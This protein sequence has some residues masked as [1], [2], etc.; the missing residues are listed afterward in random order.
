MKNSIFDFI[1]SLAPRIERPVV[2][3][4]IDDT[5]KELSEYALPMTRD[6]A[7][8]AGLGRMKSVTYLKLTKEFEA[9]G[10]RL[11]GDGNVFD[12]MIQH[13]TTLLLNAE[14]ARKFIDAYL[15]HD[16]V[17]DGITARGAVLLRTVGSMSFASRFT[18]DLLN[19]ILDE[20][21]ALNNKTRVD[22]P[23]KQSI[24]V[25]SNISRYVTILLELGNDAKGFKKRFEDMPD[26][27][28]RE[29]NADSI[30]NLY[31]ASSINIFPRTFSLNGFRGNPIYHIRLMINEWEARRYNAAKDKKVILELRLMVLQNQQSD[32]YNPMAEK[33][34]EN[35]QARIEKYDRFIR[36]TEE[37]VKD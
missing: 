6:M 27:Y 8:Q 30:S 9:Q 15:G 2:L 25:D 28:I 13:L 7:T 11:R 33:E 3:K 14:Q 29:D 35:I 1:A 23:P 16:T 21:V 34:I 24:Y 10:G 22:S 18:L 26:I 19:H 5:I 31:Q 20:E 4:D 12:R 37:S 36:E 17:R 32:S